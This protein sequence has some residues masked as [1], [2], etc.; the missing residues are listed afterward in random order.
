MLSF[1]H[2]PCLS[3]LLNAQHVACCTVFTAAIATSVCCADG[4]H[5][6][7]ACIVHVCIQVF[8]CQT[9]CRCKDTRAEGIRFSEHGSGSVQGKYQ[10]RVLYIHRLSQTEAFAVHVAYPFMHACIPN[11]LPGQ[12]LASTVCSLASRG[13]AAGSY[14]NFLAVHVASIRRY[15]SS[16]QCVANTCFVQVRTLAQTYKSLTKQEVLSGTLSELLAAL[17]AANPSKVTHVVL[18]AFNCCIS[19]LCR[20]E[21]CVVPAPWL[22]AIDC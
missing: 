6:V 14:L 4:H 12:V 10:H 9:C 16:V 17:A 8:A 11:A 3:Q 18:H 2:L 7:T 21:P 19:R 13:I 15:L 5:S 1:V 20:C 22:C